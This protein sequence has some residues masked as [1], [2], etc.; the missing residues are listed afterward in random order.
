[1][2]FFEPGMSLFAKLLTAAVGIA[3]IVAMAFFVAHG[4]LSGNEVT[5]LRHAANR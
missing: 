5:E 2:P 3:I 1:M 4:A